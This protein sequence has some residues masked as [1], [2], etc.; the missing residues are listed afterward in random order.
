MRRSTPK[1]SGGCVAAAAARRFRGRERQADKPGVTRQD[2]VDL[3]AP[4]MIAGTEGL[5]RYLSLV[6]GLVIDP[7]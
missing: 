6:F 4:A 1:E 5:C 2:R 7:D 3:L